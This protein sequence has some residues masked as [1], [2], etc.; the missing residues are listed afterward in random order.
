[1]ALLFGITKGHEG[2]L[3]GIDTAPA[4]I[5]R[6]TPMT[7]TPNTPN[8][9]PFDQAIVHPL[10]YWTL[11]DNAEGGSGK[12]VLTLCLGANF[13]FADGD[14]P[15][16]R[17]ALGQCVNELQAMYGDHL[18]WC[19]GANGGR[20]KKYKAF[21]AIAELKEVSLRAEYDRTYASH[22]PDTAD[23]YRINFGGIASWNPHRDLSDLEIRLPAHSENLPKIRDIFMRCCER[24]QPLQAFAGLTSAMAWNR[25]PWQAQ[26]YELATYFY[27]VS[28]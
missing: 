9:H 7:N 19:L 27:G 10:D 11:I 12:Q 15:E 17:E 16:K 1:V 22:D 23:E 13:Y 8:L 28:V 14:T 6:N 5:E 21:D 2:G 18:K 26:E 3:V 20:A 25:H 24:L 4:W